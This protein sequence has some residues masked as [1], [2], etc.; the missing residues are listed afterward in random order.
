MDGGHFLPLGYVVDDAVVGLQLRLFLGFEDL[1][2]QLAS[3]AMDT[4]PG[5]FAAPHRPPAPGS[6]P[7]RGSSLP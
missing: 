2:R 6:L 5:D 3:G 4:Q 7:G 1:A